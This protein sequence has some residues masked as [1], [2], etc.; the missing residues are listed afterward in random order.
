MVY[1][2][3]RS[4]L[5]AM[6]R[7]MVYE[8]VRRFGSPMI[9]PENWDDLWSKCQTYAEREFSSTR[10]MRAR[11]GQRN[12]ER[13]KHQTAVGKMGE[14][15]SQAFLCGLGYDCTSP[16][17]EVYDGK[18]KSWASDLFI[19]DHK[20]AVKTQDAVSASKFGQSW[21]F[22]KGGE[23]YGHTDPV[24]YKGKSFAVFVTLDL[25]KKCGTVN[26]PYFMSDLRP[27]FREPKLRSLRFSKTALYWDD[28]R[29]IA[30]V[31]I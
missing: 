14:F 17:C 29:D 19:G 8:G 20:V 3:V 23:G 16:D 5:K 30:P 21:I 1:V 11:R 7:R 4:A 31:T 18:G 12:P 24:I 2:G 28:I 27:H 13:I 22:Q 6:R 26:G 9:A 10:S 15:V 25:E